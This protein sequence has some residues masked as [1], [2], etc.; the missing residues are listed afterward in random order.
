MWSSICVEYWPTFKLG[1]SVE[2]TPAAYCIE[3]NV[4]YYGCTWHRAWHCKPRSHQYPLS[5]PSDYAG[6]RW[7]WGGFY[8]H[9]GRTPCWP[10]RSNQTLAL[11]ACGMSIKES[12]S[13]LVLSTRRCRKSSKHSP[14]SWSMSAKKSTNADSLNPRVLPGTG[15]CRS[16][17]LENSKDFTGS[18]RHTNPA[19]ELN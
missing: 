6:W 7:A 14:P 17:R 15:I 4:S 13:L 10:K 9:H 19:R 16:T 1:S 12:N 5:L 11:A 3:S 18:A 8:L 2:P